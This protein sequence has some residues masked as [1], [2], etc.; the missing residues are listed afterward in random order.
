MPHP[1]VLALCA[2]ETAA[3]ATVR[4]VRDQGVASE[5][6]SIVAQ[7]H[8]QESAFAETMGASPGVEIE[9]S[10]AAARIGQLSGQLIAAIALVMPGIGPI[11]T[12]GPL[13]AELGEAAGHA[14]GS[15]A[16]VLRRAGVAAD[17]AEE[18]QRRVQRGAV[19]VGVHATASNV[20]TVRA[21]LAQNGA[22]EIVIAEWQ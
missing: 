17:R 3:A 13:A 19:L 10:R 14:A 6:I 7:S 8:Q 12:A 1:L 16:G 11:V 20:E 18:W 15:L 9:D 22:T 5:Q 2:D 21:A 4:A